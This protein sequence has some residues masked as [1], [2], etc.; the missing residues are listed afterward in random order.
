MVDKTD[1]KSVAQ[2]SVR[3]QVP[4]RVQKKYKKRFGK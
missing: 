4:L 3:V 2:L 1:L